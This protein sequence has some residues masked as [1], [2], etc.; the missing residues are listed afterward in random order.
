MFSWLTRFLSPPAP[1]AP[2]L[3]S[4]A[5]DSEPGTTVR[6]MDGVVGTLTAIFDLDGRPWARVVFCGHHSSWV[7]LVDASRLLLSPAV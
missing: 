3:L 1:R 7:E 5:L 4:E 2:Q 6:T